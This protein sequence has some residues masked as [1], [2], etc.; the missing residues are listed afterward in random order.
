MSYIQRITAVLCLTL[1]A[2][3]TSSQAEASVTQNG[4]EFPRQIVVNEQPLTLT[5]TGVARYRIIFTVYAAA[6]YLPDGITSNAVLA[7]QTPRRLEIEYFHNISAEDIILAANTKLADQITPEALAEVQASVDEFHALFQSVN[8]GD[9]YRMDYIPGVGTQ[10]SFNGKPVGTVAG[11]DFAAA[12]F[13]IWLDD[14]S[15][16]SDQLRT[17]LLSGISQ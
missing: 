2:V 1:L 9:R 12:Y 14:R 17:D 5:G 10:L 4:A 13:G 3:S 7:G 16:L 8:D 15:P 11:A 6:L